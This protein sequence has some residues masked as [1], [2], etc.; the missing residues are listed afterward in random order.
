MLGLKGG[1]IRNFSRAFDSVD[2]EEPETEAVGFVT[3]TE[4]V[5][6]T[7]VTM[8]VQDTPVLRKFRILDLHVG[9]INIDV[10]LAILLGDG[11]DAGFTELFDLVGIFA[12]ESLP[13]PYLIVRV[14]SS[15][16]AGL[17]A[18][19]LA[20]ELVLIGEPG[21]RAPSS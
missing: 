5:R 12:K 20:G 10:A 13:A 11:L 9:L 7:L 1:G 16:V 4:N 15:I 21:G 2:S 8:G 14:P 17:L 3:S 6:E 19:D 18:G